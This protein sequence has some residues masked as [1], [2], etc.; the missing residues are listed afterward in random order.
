MKARRGIV[1]Q[2]RSPGRS[3]WYFPHRLK[4]Q[5]G[6][7]RA[8]HGIIRTHFQLTA[9]IQREASAASIARAMPRPDEPLDDD[10]C[11]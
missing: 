8:G 9:R 4:S 5:M 10:I 3:R 11:R 7:G 6:V 1:R 2:S